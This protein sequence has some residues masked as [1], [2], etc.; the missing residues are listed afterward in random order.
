MLKKESGLSQ[1]WSAT[2]KQQW[3]ADVVAKGPVR[4]YEEVVARLQRLPANSHCLESYG[5]VRTPLKNYPAFCVTVGDIQNGNPN[6]LIAGGVHGYEPSGVE[7]ALRFLEDEV[8]SFRNE[9]NFVVYPC[10]SP[11]SYVYDTRWNWQAEDPNRQ[12]SKDPAKTK[13]DECEIFMASMEKRACRFACAI[14]LHETS[15][16]DIELRKM[17]AERFGSKLA[18]DYQHIPQGA[19]LLLTDRDTCEGKEQQWQF[20]HSIMTVM[21]DYS[22]IAPDEM[23][24]GH[25]N[26]KGVVLSPASDGTTRAYLDQ[27]ADFVAVTEIYPDHPKMTPERTV[28][29]QI[30]SVYGAL[31]FVMP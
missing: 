21:R 20:G 9:F 31:N 12:F 13:I 24:L 17:R 1:G 28:Q 3:Y 23:I 8:Q 14:D 25:P 27:H 16:R 10:V 7:A 22:P 4:D 29:A 19:Y 11:W 5:E 15:N 26:Y 18:T 2:Q 30:A 6:I